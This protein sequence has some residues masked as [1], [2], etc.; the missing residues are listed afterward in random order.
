VARGEAA[1]PGAIAAGRDRAP[2]AAMRSLIG[3][4]DGLTS[5]D[6]GD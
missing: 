4:L 3:L 1:G 5:A 6:T 2:E